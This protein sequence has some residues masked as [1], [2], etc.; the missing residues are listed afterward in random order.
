MQ[1]FFLSN[2]QAIIHIGLLENHPS[3]DF[4]KVN[5][6]KDK[7]SCKVKF[8]RTMNGSQESQEFI[9]SLCEMLAI[10]T[11]LIR[12]TCVYER[13]DHSEKTTHTNY[14][15]DN[16]SL[17]T[18]MID[19][20]LNMLCTSSDL[21]KVL[22]YASSSGRKYD[23]LKNIFIV[24]KE[25]YLMLHDQCSISLPFDNYN[26]DNKPA[27]KANEAYESL[28]IAENFPTYIIKNALEIIQ[29]KPNSVLPL[30]KLICDLLPDAVDDDIKSLSS[31]SQYLRSY[32]KNA[33]A[34]ICDE[35][36]I[37]RH[38]I[39]S[40]DHDISESASIVLVRVCQL[41]SNSDEFQHR[42]KSML[43]RE[44]NAHVAYALHLR[45]TDEVDE[46]FTHKKLELMQNEVILRRWV[47]FTATS[48]ELGD[49][50]MYFTQALARIELPSDMMQRFTSSG[51]SSMEL[52]S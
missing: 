41:F 20:A 30:L 18:F 39:I 12:R 34:K 45:S 29:R 10:I 22:Y 23:C 13:C 26:V 33:L 1:R 36:L 51:E 21:C 43:Y 46:V 14:L 11:Q 50:H 35:L 3:M 42:I 38:F 28:G 5:S 31:S 2:L 6:C 9:C 37:L 16:S 44:M 49:I 48:I 27:K 15:T 52:N 8:L 47:T 32:W 17:A 24:E 4:K 25:V 19:G 7:T 40:N